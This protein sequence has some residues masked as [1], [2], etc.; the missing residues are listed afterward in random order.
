MKKFVMTVRISDSFCTY[1]YYLV[2][3]G[4]ESVNDVAWALRQA[5]LGRM[6]DGV[7]VKEPD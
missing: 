3:Q 4:D 7:L 2:T 5:G 1:E 6:T